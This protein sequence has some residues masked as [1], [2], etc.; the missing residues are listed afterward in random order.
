MTI[1]SA[2]WLDQ[3]ANYWKEFKKST[4]KLEMDISVS[5]FPKDLSEI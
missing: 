3:I 1:I 4:G 5:K 2:W